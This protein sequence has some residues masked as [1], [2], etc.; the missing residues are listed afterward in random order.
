MKVSQKTETAIL[1]VF[2]VA[3][4]VEIYFNLESVGIFYGLFGKT[5]LILKSLSFWII[6]SLLA[7]VGLHEF[8]SWINKK[9]S[10]HNIN[11]NP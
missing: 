3:C 2:A 1:V 6:A 10:V 11:N 5:I 8:V 7:L 9:K 4:L